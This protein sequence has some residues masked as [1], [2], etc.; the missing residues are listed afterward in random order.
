M[1]SIWSGQGY[2][3]PGLVQNFVVWEWVKTV[4]IIKCLDSR[5]REFFSNSKFGTWCDG[6]AI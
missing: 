4:T 5:S 3:I 6:N 2:T 1:L